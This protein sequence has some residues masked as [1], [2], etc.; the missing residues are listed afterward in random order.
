MRTTQDA[1]S[2]TEAL[3]IWYSERDKQSKAREGI[4]CVR[5]KNPG[6]RITRICTTEAAIQNFYY[7]PPVD[8]VAE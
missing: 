4:V 2:L 8:G 7:A 5:Q 3:E 1:H 6:H